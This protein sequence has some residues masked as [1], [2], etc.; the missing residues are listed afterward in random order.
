M[1][2][3]LTQSNLEKTNNERRNN[4]ISK[5]SYFFCLTKGILNHPEMSFCMVETGP[6]IQNLADCV[7]ATYVKSMEFCLLTTYP[8]FMS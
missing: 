3:I 8:F 2:I 5:H 7:E 1:E 6:Y 4:S